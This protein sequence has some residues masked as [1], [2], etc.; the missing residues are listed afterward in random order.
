MRTLSLPAIHEEEADGLLACDLTMTREE[1][2]RRK[3][4]SPNADEVK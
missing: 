3:P 4:I 2:S 1:K